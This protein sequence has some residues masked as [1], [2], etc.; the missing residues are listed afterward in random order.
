MKVSLAVTVPRE[1]VQ[2]LVLKMEFAITE[3]A[4]VIKATPETIALS[5]AASMTAQVKEHV[6]MALAR[7]I[8]HGLDLLAI[9]CL[10][11]TTAL[12]KATVRKSRECYSACVH[13]D[14]PDLI[15]PRQCHLGN[16]RWYLHNPT[17][18]KMFRL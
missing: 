9:N 3:N 14:G 16:G 8:P 7:A 5:E 17:Y 18:K 15:A 10:A 11:P 1:H 2:M 13:K 4:S 12:E 6:T